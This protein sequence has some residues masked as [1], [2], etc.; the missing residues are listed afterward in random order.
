MMYSLEICFLNSYCIYKKYAPGCPF[1]KPAYT[2]D[3]RMT[4]DKY[5]FIIFQLSGLSLL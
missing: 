4:N 1:I 5:L 2:K 3:K